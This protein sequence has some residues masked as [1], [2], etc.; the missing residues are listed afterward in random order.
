[1]RAWLYPLMLLVSVWCPV[2][3]SAGI[4]HQQYFS[5]SDFDIYDITAPN[6]DMFSKVSGSGMSG[7]GEIGH[8]ELPYKVVRFL[9]PDNAYDFNVT[10]ESMEATAPL[11]LD[12]TI[13]PVQKPIPT[14]LYS[15][16]VFTFPDEETYRSLKT[17]IRAE[18]L[19]ESRLEGRYHIVSVGLWPLA[20]SGNDKEL[21]MCASMRINLDFKEKAL[22]KQKSNSSNTAGFIDISDMVVNAD[23]MQSANVSPLGFEFGGTIVDRTLPYYYI[24]SERSLIPAL[25][26]LSTWK[27]QKGYRVVTK[28][29]EDIYEDSKYKVGTNGIVDEAAS[30]R[31]YLQDEYALYGTFFCL[32]VGDYRTKMPIRKAYWENDETKVDNVNGD[33]YIPTD[34][35]FS[36]LSEDGWPLQLDKAGIYRAETSASF[37]PNI[38]VGRLLCNEPQEIYNYTK[39]LIL[40]ETNPGRGNSDYLDKTTLTVMYDGRGKYKNVKQEMESLFTDVECLLDCKISNPKSKGYPSSKLMFDK[41]NE[42]GYCSWIGHGEPSAVACSGDKDGGRIVWEYVK[43]LTSYNY[44][45]DR[46]GHEDPTNVSSG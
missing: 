21:E 11:V 44:D 4:V 27:T 13:Y 30:L 42:S 36:D 45:E 28:A 38:Y 17:T 20:Y 5:A 1:M 6:G 19:D 33:R 32:L 12:N 46:D 14:S 2:R 22:L 37:N 34:N 39:K 10:V 3:L 41:L 16:N 15:E 8:P 18:I 31:K 43:A 40:Y 9:V 23:A 29:I 7:S 35:Y 25:K 24:I 26:D